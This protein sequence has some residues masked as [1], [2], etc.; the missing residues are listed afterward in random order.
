MLGA[1]AGDII[2][3]VHE[4][5][6][7]KTKDFPL[8]GKFCHFTDDTVL[9]ISVASRLLKGG[10][11]VDSFHDFFHAYPNAGYSRSRSN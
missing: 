10:D 4:H 2:G 7:T 9:T 8:F 1:I 11:Y 6:G 5:A 3:S